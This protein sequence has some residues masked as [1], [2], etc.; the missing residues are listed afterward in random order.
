ML[1]TLDEIMAQPTE[2]MSSTT[3]KGVHQM[4]KLVMLHYARKQRDEVVFQRNLLATAE[5]ERARRA[6][7]GLDVRDRDR[8]IASLK[9]QLQK[10]ENPTSAER[11]TTMQSLHSGGIMMAVWLH[12]L[13]ASVGNA[14][15]ASSDVEY[16][17]AL[18]AKYQFDL[19]VLSQSEDSGQSV[20]PLV[21]RV[22]RDLLAAVKRRDRARVLEICR[23][24]C[25]S[26]AKA[27]PALPSG[28]SWDPV[29]G[30]VEVRR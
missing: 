30:F 19:E 2:E 1:A 20:P 25:E 28:W 24:H 10:L 14:S 29:L 9:K 11:S 21:D 17:A 12:P 27:A 5:S 26:A 23:P 4:A 22:Y 3:E 7:R 16:F 13:P 15:S 18:Q 6:E 8:E